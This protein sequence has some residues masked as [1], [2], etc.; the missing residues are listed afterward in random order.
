[1]VEQSLLVVDLL[2]VVDFVVLLAIVDWVA[3]A[4]MAIV[5]IEIL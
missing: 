1:M 2:M 4:A 3:L 5:A